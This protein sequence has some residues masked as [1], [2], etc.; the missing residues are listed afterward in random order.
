M[1]TNNH[2]RERFV[3]RTVGQVFVCALLGLLVTGCAGLKPQAGPAG[4]GVQIIQLA[5]RLGVNING[6]FF[7]EYVFQDTPRPYCYPV[8]GPGG[9][10]MTRNFPMRDVLVEYKYQK[11]DR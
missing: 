9:A 1:K 2:T 7:T 11:N 10:G 3:L 5:D 6:Q 4:K 8:L